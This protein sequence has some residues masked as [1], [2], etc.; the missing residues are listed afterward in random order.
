MAAYEGA[1]ELE[2]GLEGE[3]WRSGM[4]KAV[5]GRLPFCIVGLGYLWK[6]RHA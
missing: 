5:K 4:V 1:S 3:H 6:G 2:L